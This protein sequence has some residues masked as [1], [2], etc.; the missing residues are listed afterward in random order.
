MELTPKQQT[1]ELVR[2]AERILVVTHTGLDGDAVGSTLALAQALRKLGKEVALAAPDPV[3]PVFHFL[4]GYEEIEQELGGTKDFILY[5]DTSRVQVE[6][7]GYKNVTDEKRLKIII[8]P[9]RGGFTPADVSYETGPAR[10]DLVIVLDTPALERLDRFFNAQA[11]FFYETPLINI[12]HHPGNDFFG[13]VN[14]VD[15]T[16][17]STAEILVALLESLGRE[18]SL[19]D[20]DIATLLLA[21][22]IT[23]TESF[24]NAITT[25]K[26][27]TVAAQL[28]AAGARQ[29]EIVQQIYRTKTLS[30]LRL[31]G[32]ALSKIEEDQTHRFLWSKIATADLKASGADE[33]ELSGVADELLRS[34]PNIDFVLLLSERRGGSIYGSLRSVG[35]GIDV[36]EIA[37]LFGGGGQPAAAAFR[38]PNVNLEEAEREVV[39]RLQ[40]FQRQ[41]LALDS[42]P[43]QPSSATAPKVAPPPPSP[44]PVA[45][46]APSPASD[47]PTPLPS[48]PSAPI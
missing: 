16:A 37:K 22:I 35:R 43:A 39:D 8:T 21:G 18:K 33:S 26:S 27:L 25:P 34:A 11:Q 36:S 6:K 2:A 28:V 29:Q 5:L 32:K 12:D 42:Q 20:P 9:E 41:R 47:E 30:T 14:W 10:V 13:K 48:D 4:P 19:L 24:Q 45:A 31:W 46:P 7:L 44:A 23:D 38:I 1:V 15:L 17:T 40:S 3:P